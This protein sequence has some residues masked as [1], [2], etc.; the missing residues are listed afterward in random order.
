MQRL[1]PGAFSSL[2]L[3][4]SPLHQYFQQ[5]AP[6][7]YRIS[8]QNAT[9]IQALLSCQTR[10]YRIPHGYGPLAAEA[11]KRYTERL[12]AQLETPSPPSPTSAAAHPANISPSANERPFD[13]LV[14]E[15]HL[16]NSTYTHHCKERLALCDLRTQQYDR[17]KALENRIS[18]LEKE[19]SV[20]IARQ[21]DDQF[22]EFRSLLTYCMPLTHPNKH[23]IYAVWLWSS[24][25]VERMA[26]ANSVKPDYSDVDQRLREAWER[27]IELRKEFKP[28]G[29]AKLAEEVTHI[30]NVKRTEGVRRTEDGQT[31]VADSA[32][33]SAIAVACSEGVLQDAGAGPA[34]LGG[35]SLAAAER[36]GFITRS[37]ES[38]AEPGGSF[39]TSPCLTAEGDG[40]VAADHRPVID[41][42]SYG[43]TGDSD[44]YGRD[45]Y[46]SENS[47][48]S[49]WTE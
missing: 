41:S 8:L 20:G 6:N 46:W 27:V 39:T 21:H 26:R 14:N 25:K 3:A 47:D 31:G 7:T 28:A 13:E 22:R 1:A 35:G 38:V 19:V 5:H 44:S 15:L 34:V 43:W 4:T 24:Q 49:D 48:D 23:A 30:E 11:Y 37:A 33:I 16:I 2:R 42:A 9:R 32:L 45:S 40:N 10:C 36:A 18:Q 12:K 17:T 29:D